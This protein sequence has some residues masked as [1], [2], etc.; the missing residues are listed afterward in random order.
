MLTLE[1]FH[2]FK[3]I[4]LYNFVTLLNMYNLNVLVSLFLKSFFQF[5]NYDAAFVCDLVRESY[6]NRAQVR[7]D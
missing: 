5:Y 2:K 6:Y 7:D 1:E 3:R 4:K